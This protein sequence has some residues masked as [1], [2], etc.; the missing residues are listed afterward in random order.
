M[1]LASPH[2]A[3][4]KNAYRDRLQSSAFLL[5]FRRAK[6][7]RA[8]IHTAHK[9]CM[10]AGISWPVWAGWRAC[11]LADPGISQ[12]FLSV[13]SKKCCMLCTYDEQLAGSFGSGTFGTRQAAA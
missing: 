8:V 12:G 6:R 1:Q 5:G 7:T 13:S 9:C 11:S 4:E 10:Q 3:K 2:P